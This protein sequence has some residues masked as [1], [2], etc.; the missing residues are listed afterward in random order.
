MNRCISPGTATSACKSAPI[1]RYPQNSILAHPKLVDDPR[2]CRLGEVVFGEGFPDRGVE[3]LED[4]VHIVVDRWSCRG[5]N[6]FVTFIY[7]GK[8]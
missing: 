1:R 8:E 2:R 6:Q 4:G 7:N 5:Y 3:F